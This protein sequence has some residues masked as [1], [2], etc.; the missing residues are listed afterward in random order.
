MNDSE[1]LPPH[2][3][4]RILDRLGIQGEPPT[5]LNGLRTVYA[6]WCRSVPFDNI[7]KLTHLASGSSDPL[8]GTDAVSF[9]HNW[10]QFGTGGLCWAGNNALFTLLRALGYS[11]ERVLATMEIGA[12]LSPNH[13]SVAVRFGDTA[14]LVDA[15]LLHGE[16]IQLDGKKETDVSH[17][18]WGISCLPV[19]G[20]WRLSA[21]LP[22]MVEGCSCLL[23]RFGVTREDYDRLNEA[24]RIWS[25][26]NFSLY[27]RRN[28]GE[29]VEA[30][31]Y[32]KRVRFEPDGRVNVS[33]CDRESA[34][35]FLNQAMGIDRAVLEKL[36]LDRD[37]KF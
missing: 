22:H 10:L 16:P 35:R 25:P 23:N 36:P 34:V 3:A 11:P 7:S 2:L 17:P 30:L 18:A 5:D 32:G 4:L 14:Y 15:S 27:Y 20:T 21:R 19:G 1:K 13:G 6:A 8:P 28:L 29:R 9:F 31:A 26:F 33:D 37:P 12:D 24:T